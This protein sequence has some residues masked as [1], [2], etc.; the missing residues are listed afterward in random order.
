[1]ESAIIKNRKFFLNC[2]FF[3]HRFYNFQSKI[4]VSWNICL[5]SSAEHWRILIWKCYGKNGIIV[6]SLTS[7]NN[8]GK[9]RKFKFLH[10]KFFF[11]FQKKKMLRFPM[12]VS[13]N[14]DNK[15]KF[16]LLIFVPQ[17]RIKEI[18]LKT[19]LFFVKYF[20]IIIHQILYFVWRPDVGILILKTVYFKTF[21]FFK[22][23]FSINFLNCYIN[24][25]V[26]WK[27][28]FSK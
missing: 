27:F 15:I 23:I 3:F 12:L 19:F 5:R 20:P 28:T 16:L 14:L 7:L 26:F 2:F 11:S 10:S 9:P 17:L 1:M 8:K 22:F 25:R 21:L 6:F 18:L 4:I 24:S 13:E